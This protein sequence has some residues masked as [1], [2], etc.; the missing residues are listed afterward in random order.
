MN[1]NILH[2]MV[3]RKSWLI[4]VIGNSSHTNPRRLPWSRKHDNSILTSAIVVVLIEI[5]VI[6][7]Y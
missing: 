6:I 3:S 7:V 1:F 5:I 2:F 4:L